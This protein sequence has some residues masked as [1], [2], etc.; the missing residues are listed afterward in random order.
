MAS[1][2]EAQLAI[3]AG[4]DAVGFVGQ[5]SSSSPRAMD[6]GTIRAIATRVPPP[7]ATFL[8]TA[9]PTAAGISRHVHATGVSAVQ[10]L[11]HLRPS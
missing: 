10:I 5:T 2:E 8:L 1:F 11:T 7:I 6:D 3:G 4:A 9:E